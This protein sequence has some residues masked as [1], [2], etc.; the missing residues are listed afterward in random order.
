MKID[1]IYVPQLLRMPG[2]AQTIILDDVIGGIKTL[3]PIR[4]NLR[5]AH[6]GNFLE[7]QLAVDTIVTLNCDR[8]L[9]T[10][11][12]RLKVETEEI[13]WLSYE[14]E[15][16]QNIA[17]EREISTEDLCETLSPEGYFP[18]ENWLYEQVSLAMPLRKLCGNNCQPPKNP[19]ES[20][21]ESI[22]DD[23]WSVLA[24]WNL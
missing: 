14:R 6:R 1:A 24:N 22:I 21:T 7:V 18:V 11:N 23:R 8:C 10:Y 12:H 5:V 15:Q 17:L 4:G 20:E 19:C 13:I 3:T 9:K 16:D 2:K